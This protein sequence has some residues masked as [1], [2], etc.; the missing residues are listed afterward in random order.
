MGSPALRRV[1]VESEMRWST[2]AATMTGN[3]GYGGLDRHKPC[4]FLLRSSLSVGADV[5]WRVWPI[6]GMWPG[7]PVVVPNVIVFHDDISAFYGFWPVSH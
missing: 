2:P 1:V 3:R 7:R 4:I 5:R 6:V